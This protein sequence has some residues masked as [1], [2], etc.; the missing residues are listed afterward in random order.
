[1]GHSNENVIIYCSF[2]LPFEEKGHKK[3]NLIGIDY[4]VCQI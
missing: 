4:I 2:V 3:V 1:M